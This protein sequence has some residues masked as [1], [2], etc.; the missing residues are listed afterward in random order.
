MEFSLSFTR[1][2]IPTLINNSF[3]KEFAFPP[4]IIPGWPPEEKS[5]NT[6]IK[7]DNHLESNTGLNTEHGFQLTV[8]FFFLSWIACLK[9]NGLKRP[10]D[11]IFTY[12]KR[13]NG[14]RSFNPIQTNI[15][16]IFSILLF[17]HFLRY[18]Q[19]EFVYQSKA[20]SV[21]DHFLYSNDLYVWFRGDILRRNLMLVTLRVL[22]VNEGSFHCNFAP[23]HLCEFAPRRKTS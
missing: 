20:S 16:C 8:F 1:G 14:I 21:G 4:L 22:R 19:G 10:L 5:V 2:V 17:I 23:N 18:W 3:R 6:S 12:L 15:R 7:N 9:Q 11:T 13:H